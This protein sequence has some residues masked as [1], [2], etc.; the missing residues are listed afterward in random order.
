MEFLFRPIERLLEGGRSGVAGKL[1]AAGGLHAAA[2]RSSTS[3]TSCWRSFLAHTFLAYFVG[4][5]QL[6]Q[7][8]QRSPLEHPTAFLVMAVTTALIFF[9]F[10]YFREQTCLVACPYGRLQSVLLDR[11]SLIVAYDTQRGEPRAHQVK[12]RADGR[13]RLRRLRRLRADLPHRHRHPRRAADGVHPLHPVHGRLRRG[14]GQGRQAA[15]LIR[16]TLAR[17]AGGQADSPAAPARACSTRRRSPSLLGLLVCQLGTQGRHRRHRCCA[18]P[19]A[20]YTRRARRQRRQPGAPQD[21]QPRRRRAP[22]RHR[23][24]D[25]GDGREADRAA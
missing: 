12:D 19:G 9:D 16:Y 1:D 15:G 8:V 23:S 5:E 17:R 21:R 20:P 13:R 22:L 14:H 2:A 4:I 7:W 10:A 3:S 24:V 18:A 25:G 6:A 11:Q